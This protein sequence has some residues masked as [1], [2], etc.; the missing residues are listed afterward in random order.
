M[1]K[2]LSELLSNLEEDKTIELIEKNIAEDRPVMEIFSECRKGMDI[3]GNRYDKGE[4]FVADLM[5]AGNIFNKAM[6]LLTPI[7]KENKEDN[8]KLGKVLLATVKDDIHDLGKNL[9]ATMLNAS[10]F[11]I[12]D[13]GVD[14]SE[15]IIYKKIE[16]YKPDIVGLSCLI[17]TALSSMENTVQ[18]IKKMNDNQLVIVGGAP[19]TDSITQ[20]IGA[21]A[22]GKDASD[23][24][25]KCKKLLKN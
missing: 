8:K 20:K 19:I 9:V 1:A 11:E 21:D 13:I 10:N 14:V 12:V 16:E 17:N 24:V 18:G 2:K 7:I 23:A 5:F 25:K 6:D 15:D 22:Y 4:Y 3:V